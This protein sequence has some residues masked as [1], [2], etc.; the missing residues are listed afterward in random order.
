[1]CALLRRHHDPG[2]H[3]P[4]QVQKQKHAKGFF[5]EKFHPSENPDKISLFDGHSFYAD[6]F[7]IR[8]SVLIRIPN[9]VMIER[10]SEFRLLLNRKDS[11]TEFFDLGRSFNNF[12]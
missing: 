5:K 1:L 4:E 3:G 6:L 2:F 11:V 8:F 7:H 10:G 9:L 12:S